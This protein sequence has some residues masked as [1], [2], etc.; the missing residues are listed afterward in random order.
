MVII[1]LARCPRVLS[2]GAD[3]YNKCVLPLSLPPSMSHREG[4]MQ[5]DCCVL[6]M[7]HVHGKTILVANR[8]TDC[9]VGGL[10]GHLM[11]HMAYVIL[12]FRF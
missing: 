4:T 11:I 8:I 2:R 9:R 6:N 5:I 12:D 3:S 1:A 10:M 7:E